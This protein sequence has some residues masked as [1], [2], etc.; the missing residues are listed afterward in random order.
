MLRQRKP[1]QADPAAVRAWQDR[2]RRPLARKAFW[3]SKKGTLIRKTAIKQRNEKAIARRRKVYTTY[4]RSAEWLKLRYDRYLLDDGYCQCEWCVQ[5]RKGETKE[6]NAARPAGVT[7]SEAFQQ[8]PVYFTASGTAPWRRI[9]G[10]STHHVRYDLINPKPSDLRT[11]Y[12]HHHDATEAKYSTR[13]R[14]LGGSK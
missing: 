6:Q 11:M 2:S 12:P 14:Y 4:L 10:F 9:R 7:F 5:A 3:Q 8:I 1:L 13:R